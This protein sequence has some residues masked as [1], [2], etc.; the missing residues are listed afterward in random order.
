MNES[1][2]IEEA[3]VL[4]REL[5]QCVVDAIEQFEEGTGLTV[6]GIH[7]DGDRDAGL[8]VRTELVFEP[9]KAPRAR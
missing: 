4:R 1:I 5:V 9:D 3:K 6:T 2:T 8:L 7:Y